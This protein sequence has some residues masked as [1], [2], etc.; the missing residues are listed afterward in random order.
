[1]SNL[2]SLPS[3]E[4]IESRMAGSNKSL[5]VIKAFGDAPEKNPEPSE[6]KVVDKYLQQQ[7]E[8]LRE[9]AADDATLTKENNVD[10][11][12]FSTQGGRNLWQGGW[13]GKRPANLVDGSVDWRYWERGRQARIYAEETECVVELER[14]RG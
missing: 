6:P 10:L 1:M 7:I 14:P 9:V 8:M 11:N 12:P 13:D 5:E 2:P 3:V 4:I